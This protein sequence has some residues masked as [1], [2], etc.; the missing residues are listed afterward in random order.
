MN[1]LEAHD[2]SV[3]YGDTPIIEKLSL[4]IRQGSFVGILGP[5]G[6][7]KTT[8]LRTMTRILKPVEGE[9]LINGNNINSFDSRTLAKTIGCVSQE[10]RV[11]FSFTVKDV[12]LMG[13]HPYIGRLSP[14]SHDD[15][16]ITDQ[17]MKIT[18]V[19]HLADRSV[20]EISGGERQRV[21]I[22]RT[23]AQNPEIL[24]LDEPTSHLDINHQIEIL[25]MI[26]ALT[27]KITVIGVLHD[28]NL[29][30]YFCD[31]IVLMKKG[32]I[33]AVGSP[34]EVL[35]RELIKDV[36]SIK[37]MISSH[38]LTGKPYLIPEYGSFSSPDSRK[39]HVV[40]GAG[41]GTEV[42]YSLCMRGFS[43]TAGV[44]SLGDSDCET[45]KTL[46]IDTIIEKP[47]AAVTKE[48]TDRATVLVKA[49]DYIVVTSMPV[50]EGN[51]ANLEILQGHGKKVFF[52]GNTDDRMHG[53]ATALREKLIAEGAQWVDNI[54]ELIK[55][56]T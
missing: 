7:G 33:V 54:T 37:M 3:A 39:V 46:G 16:K 51:Y 34:Q 41:S 45:A 35:T 4:A 9:I 18:N 52:I 27:P 11:A 44:L 14:L 12:V 53:K 13:R 48:A 50:G 19:A 24:F 38:P 40:S 49:A 28:L 56:I 21:L 2:I 42:F 23:L 47:F 55:R 32:K 22:A 15:L 30:S 29:A 8:L 1:V 43:V 26:Q 5:N 31:T 17:A 25:S 20:T 10:T 36:F 6:C